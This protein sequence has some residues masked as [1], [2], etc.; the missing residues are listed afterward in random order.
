LVFK[1]L[2]QSGRIFE[3]EESVTIWITDDANKIPIKMNASLAIGSL[4]AEL[5]AHKGLANPFGEI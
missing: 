4:R 1:P 3:A 2:V 5:E